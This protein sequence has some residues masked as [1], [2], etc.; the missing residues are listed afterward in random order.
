MN[1]FERRERPTARLTMEALEDRNAATAFGSWTFGHFGSWSAHHSPKP[2]HTHHWAPPSQSQGKHLGWG[3]GR[4]GGHHQPPVP[5][6]PPPA[7]TG[8]VSGV[9]FVDGNFDGTRDP[10]EQG[11]AGQVVWADTGNGVLDAGEVSTT[12]GA[13]GS[14]VLAGLRANSTVVISAVTGNGAAYTPATVTVVAGQTVSGADVAV[15][16]GTNS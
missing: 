12:T 1:E 9:V 15:N 16:S 5:P 6:V 7:Q 8:S 13:D 2:A 3:H 10:G 11:L 4:C 14:Y